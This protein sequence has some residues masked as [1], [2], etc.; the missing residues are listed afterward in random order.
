MICRVVCGCE[1]LVRL[2]VAALLRNSSSS[3]PMSD[4]CCLE[5]KRNN[6]NI[7]STEEFVTRQHRSLVGSPK[8]LI[9]TNFVQ[10]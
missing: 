10:F 7:L 8:K 9:R 3:N 1:R 5:E 6:N 4:G 2:Q